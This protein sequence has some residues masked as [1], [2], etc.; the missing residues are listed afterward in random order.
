MGLFDRI[1]GKRGG[2]QAP[3]AKPQ[4]E[5][6]DALPEWASFFGTA[7]RYRRFESIV[8]AY[9]LRAN[10]PFVI[11]DGIVTI[12]ETP[13]AGK[14]PEAV[15]RTLGLGNVAQVCAQEQTSE[16]EGIIQKHFDTVHHSLDT[17]NAT[18]GMPFEEA[19]PRL[20]LRLWDM[21]ES[22]VRAMSVWR[23]D[24]PGIASVLCVD[25]PHAIRSLRLEEDVKPWNIAKNELFTMALAN[26]PTLAPVAVQGTDLDDGVTIHEILGDS[27]FSSSWALRLE[28]WPEL[29]GEYGM[30]LSVPSRH[31]VLVLP[32]RNGADLQALG[33][34][35][36]ITIGLEKEGPGS[37]SNRVFW[38]HRGTVLEIEY[39]IEEQTLHVRPPEEFVK[40]LETLGE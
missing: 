12:F 16:W 10:M 2:Q 28:E 6:S 34:M 25:E 17:P 3:G 38:R 20:G 23:E 36:H 15:K 11:E 26:L 4:A 21:T 30:F 18:E 14:E 9:H 5:Q 32:I 29:Q 31:R 35:I 24:L 13:E 40:I 39:A 33:H 22:N 7:A 8:R 37:V 19:Q 27:P 1:F